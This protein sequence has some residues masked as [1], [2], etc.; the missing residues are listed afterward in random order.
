MVHDPSVVVFKVGRLCVS[1]A[2]LSFLRVEHIEFTL[3]AKT[4]GA[5]RISPTELQGIPRP[6]MTYSIH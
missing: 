2:D 3:Q 1:A 4:C 5:F 6:V